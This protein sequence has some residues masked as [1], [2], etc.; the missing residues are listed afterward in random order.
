MKR[1]TLLFIATLLLLTAC[2]GCQPN[3]GIVKPKKHG[4]CG[5]CPVW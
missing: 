5:T 3:R 1:N 4:K 2:Y